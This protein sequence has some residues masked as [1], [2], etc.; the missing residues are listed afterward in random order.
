MK[1]CIIMRGLPGSG[2]STW[3]QR[4]EPNA[5]VWSADNY[6]LQ[7]GVYRYDKAKAKEAHDWCLN[8]F[9]QS[10]FAYSPL[11]AVDNTNVKA[12]EF[13]PYY[14]AAEALG[15]E[16]EI[17]WVVAPI[18][19]CILRNVHGVPSETIQRMARSFEPIPDWWNVRMVVK[20]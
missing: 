20:E 10:L 17:V 2:K 13:S 12:F 19:K 7:E 9:L 4:N 1:R 11:V 14:R 15:Y 16:V 6:H 5:V 18:E 3:L 8:R